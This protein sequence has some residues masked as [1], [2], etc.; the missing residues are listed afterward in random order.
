MRSGAKRAIR[1]CEF[2]VCIL[3]FSTLASALMVSTATAAEIARV[4]PLSPPSIT[5][6]AVFVS[7]ATSGTE[8]FARDP[9]T[10]LPPASLTKLVAALVVV[11]RAKLDD[12]IEILQDDVVDA[13]ESQVGLV[14]GDILS[15]H[16]LLIGMLV[17]SGNDATLALARY[18]G[19]QTLPEP[20]TPAQ[21]VDAFVSMMNGKVK[22]LGANSSHFVNPTGIDADG[23]V[24]SAR[25]VATVAEVALQNSVI[26]EIIST[27]SAVLPS[28]KRPEGYGVTTTNLLLQEGVVQGGKT[29]STPMAGGCL[30]TAFT[31]DKNE[32]VTVVL[33]SDVR[34]AADGA[35]VNTARFDDT[36]T[37]I[38]AVR[39]DF[40][41]MN[42][43]EPGVIAG[44]TDELAVWDVA[45]QSGDL[46]PVPAS[47]AAKIRYRVV[48][49]PPG[50]SLSEVGEVEFYV[51]DR[52]LS[53]L[54]TIQ[55]DSPSST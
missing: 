51:G 1:R 22:E 27:P 46:L 16:D 13:E 32:V 5:A 10:P 50:N 47:S 36:R 17:P 49:S 48:L 9:D 19:G 12:K 26:A 24:M 23:H 3:V 11:E 34:E 7:D 18:V 29:G 31:V 28:E 4:E 44:L 14:T 40:L 20:Y 8:L 43:A 45:L 52:Y 2:F 35:Q 33:G 15:V 25:D 37:L 42:P 21:A 53:G 41:W 55:L 30:V 6:K 39:S 38:D 54:P